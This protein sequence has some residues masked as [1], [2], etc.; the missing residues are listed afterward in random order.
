MIY[1][2]RINGTWLSFT[3]KLIR[4]PRILLNPGIGIPNPG[5][6]SRGNIYRDPGI[7]GLQTLNILHKPTMDNDCY[8]DWFVSEYVF[9]TS[10]KHLEH[11]TVDDDVNS[12]IQNSVYYTYFYL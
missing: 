8:F 10:A 11:F 5:I 4:I 9:H 7:P 6:E 1:R 2:I 12:I 3:I